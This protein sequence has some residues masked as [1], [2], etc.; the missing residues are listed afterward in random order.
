MKIAITGG[1]FSPAYSVIKKLLNEH[2]VIVIGRKYA[3]AKDKKTTFEYK[4]CSKLGVEFV[5]LKTG[6][7]TRS[8][9]FDSLITFSKFPFGVY[10]S[11]KILKKFRADV[12]L[13]FGGYLGLPVAIASKLLGVPVILHEQTQKAGLS[14]KLISK[15]AEV[16]LVSFENSKKY[17]PNNKTI[18]TGNPLRP[19]FF[20]TGKKEVKKPSIYITGGS[21][22]S[23]F[24][25]M[26]I[27]NILPSL[28]KKYH[29]YHQAGNASEFDDLERLT[30]IKNA[31]YEVKDFYEPEDVF[32]L[33]KNVD[34]VISR[35]G[36]N[37]VNEIIASKCISLLIPL[38]VGQ[39][40]EQLDNAKLVKELGYGEYMLQDEVT[41]TN[42]L[43]QI[44]AI[45]E[46]KASYKG[47][48]DKVIDF[49]KQDSVELIIEQL[50]R[51]GRKGKNHQ[52]KEGI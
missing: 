5:D 43:E 23:H 45:I 52:K 11:L 40:N 46:N 2:D 12:C 49:V 13:T 4:V 7:F 31:R 22:G 50:I 1:H 9:S 21:T 26:T 51:Y 28:L 17:F 34:L 36:A 35:A 24:I 15:F 37:T 25:N 32:K 16:I 19:E 8:I 33:L 18:L 10:A 3:F 48:F 6:K 14:A 27:E 38:P 47:K 30:S 29:I 39:I 20:G 44:D 42:L 41:S